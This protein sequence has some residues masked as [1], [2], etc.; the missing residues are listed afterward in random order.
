[1]AEFRAER[2]SCRVKRATKLYAS[3]YD[4]NPTGTVVPA[5][6]IFTSYKQYSSDKIGYVHIT[7]GDK[8]WVGLWCP[9]S[10]VQSR[11]IAVKP[12]D[13][14]EYPDGSESSSIGLI[15]KGSHVVVYETDQGTRE[16]PTGFKPGD[17]IVV[18][19]KLEFTLNGVP[20]VR[21]R[22]ASTT[23]E[24][25]SVIGYW[26][27]I[28]KNVGEA[29]SRFNPSIPRPVMKAARAT[30]STT[31]TAAVATTTSDTHRVIYTDSNGN[32]T[33]IDVPNYQSQG[34]S[35]TANT[36]LSSAD[37]AYITNAF[38]TFS[39]L[40]QS[41]HAI[42]GYVPVGRMLFIHG[43]AFQY[44]HLTDRR[45]G[46]NSNF[47][48]PSSGTS[49]DIYGNKASDNSNEDQ[50]GRSFAKEIA[51]N[52]PIAVLVAGKPDFLRPVSKSIF[53]LNG[54][55]SN[56][57]KNGTFNTLLNAAE[58]GVSTALELLDDHGSGD[59]EYYSLDIDNT[60]Y[61]LY[62]NSLA[63]TSATLM[64]IGDMMY[65]GYRLSGFNWATYNSDAT[66]DF[67]TFEDVL[68]MSSGVSFAFDPQSSFSSTIQNSTQESQFTGLFNQ[69]S[70]T[71]R[72]IGFIAGITGSGMESIQEKINEQSSTIYGTG[73]VAGLENAVSRIKA[74]AL[75]SA[76][77]MNIRFPEIWS[78]SNH[79]P[80]YEMDVHFIA[81]YATPFCI[82]RYVLVPFYHLFA[83]AAPQSDNNA[84]Q[85]S[86][87]FLIKA[88]SKGY[89]NV[90]MGI[91]DSITWKRFGD[92]DMISED[93]VPTQI[94]VSV[95]FKDLYHALTITNRGADGVSKL[96]NFVN[97]AGLMEM[98]GTMSGVNMTRMSP[99]DRI[100]LLMAAG[101]EFFNQI[102]GFM[103]SKVNDSIRNSL[104]HIGINKIV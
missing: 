34:E 31:N 12:Q 29:V 40:Y 103:R 42:H 48:K 57:M 99:G 87:P 95:T 28:D 22:I 76:K 91:I 73:G 38:N 49:A 75:N 81:P 92:G 94:D 84:S 63:Q 69:L 50:Y 18:D 61:F 4:A 14:I 59:Y 36:S 60:E 46:A 13:V 20:T 74:W 83:L 26:V 89:F 58:T 44:T 104:A 71:A 100:T 3:V 102:G 64:G 23:S 65:H 17:E 5:G 96:S 19:R 33:T 39:D 30:T 55:S 6:T 10:A 15:V 77:G 47:G 72:E 56:G 52:V 79:S 54:S 66:Q 85:Y 41:S 8:D 80:S 45:N 62:V 51:F 43:M 25:Q 97:N 93:G 21:Y 35:I 24:D 88:Y 9:T 53:G 16:I 70:G 78:D 86:A 98:V 101:R 67:K 2:L 1:M 90:E 68:G 7:D 37:Y 32:V 82:W 11:T 27:T